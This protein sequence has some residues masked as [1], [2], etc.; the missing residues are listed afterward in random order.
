MRTLHQRCVQRNEVHHTPKSQFLTQQF[1]GNPCLD[2]TEFRVKEQFDRVIPRLAVDVFEKNPIQNIKVEVLNG[3]GIKGIA[4]K[5]AD[6]LRLYQVDVVR[7][8]NA[9]RYDY[10]NTIIIARNAN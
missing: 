8:D 7:S 1:A 10:P 3:C 9:D 4:A 5:T 6:F 2:E